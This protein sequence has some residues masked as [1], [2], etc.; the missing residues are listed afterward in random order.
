M[1][2]NSLGSYNI[3]SSARKRPFTI[4]TNT[5]HEF[6][7]KDSTGIHSDTTQTSSN[8][9][10]KPPNSSKRKRRQPPATHSSSQELQGQLDLRNTKAITP[11][12][13]NL[14]HKIPPQRSVPAFLHKLYKYVFFFLILSLNH[15][16]I[17]K[18][19]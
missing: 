13:I 16:N 2:Q 10:I 6:F 1:A 18:R 4:D 11:V 9:S 3:S 7:N 15:I 5:Q 12:Y 14:P 17:Q 19:V 8:T